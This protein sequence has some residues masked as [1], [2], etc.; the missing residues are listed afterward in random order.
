MSFPAYA[1]L[2]SKSLTP[3]YVV[4]SLYF[5]MNYLML[6]VA[7]RVNDESISAQQ[8]FVD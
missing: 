7:F 6:L 5:A 4:V 3:Q 8:H 2:T 1:L